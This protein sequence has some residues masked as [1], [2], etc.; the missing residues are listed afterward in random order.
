M[1]NIVKPRGGYVNIW[2]LCQNISGL[3]FINPDVTALKHGGTIEMKA[4]NE[5]FELI[6]KKQK[7]LVI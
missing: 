6:K 5:F 4:E 7:N 3:F 1:N 2:S